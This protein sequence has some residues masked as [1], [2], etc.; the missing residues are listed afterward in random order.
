[1]DESNG[2][3]MDDIHR[4]VVETEHMSAEASRGWNEWLYDALDQYRRDSVLP[5]VDA[6]ADE[7]GALTG[8]AAREQDE[9]IKRLENEIAALRTDLAIAQA[10]VRGTVAALPLKGKAHAA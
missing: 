10:I 3:A 4:P 6:L 7:L 2:D 1:L 9:K 5:I 8:K